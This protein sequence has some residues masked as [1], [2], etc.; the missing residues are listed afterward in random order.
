MKIFA[1]I[2][3]LPFDRVDNKNTPF[4]NSLILNGKT[5]FLENIMGY[6]FGIQSTLL[7]GKLPSET[8]QWMPYVHSTNSGLTSKTLAST[9]RTFNRFNVNWT[10]PFFLKRLH[11]AFTGNFVIHKG[12]KIASI[13]FSVIDKFCIK[14]YYYMHELP[15]YLDFKQSFNR[16]GFQ[17]HYFGPILH[18]NPIA[19][20]ISSIR[21]REVSSGSDSFSF[22]Y[23]DGLDGIGHNFGIDS[24]LWIETLRQTDRNLQSL[25]NFFKSQEIEF[26][27]A[28]FSDHEMCNAKE[29][30][31]LPL[32]L[33]Q[34]GISIPKDVILFVDATIALI[35]FN[36]DKAKN[37]VR[38]VLEKIGSEK[39]VVIQKDE[40]LLEKSGVLFKDGEYGD[41]IIQSKPGFIFFPNYYSDLYPLIGV[42]GFLPSEKYQRAFLTL[43]QDCSC[44]DSPLH[45]KD[46][47]RTIEKMMDS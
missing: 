22:L 2:D 35:W 13:P 17:C 37:I 8:G 20:L 11:A 29:I 25:S 30:I 33:K 45:I 36:N 43:P 46:I 6:S 10:L 15:E 3:A 16:K 19:S 31:N 38:K 47:R 32:F 27:L 42:H 7:S 1:Y 44:C 24:N 41:L 4:L 23:L 21:N 26:K 28:I 34:M 40:K 5:H 14:P 39:L 18:Q 12:A 9:A